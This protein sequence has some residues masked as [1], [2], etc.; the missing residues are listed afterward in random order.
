MEGLILELH[1]EAQSIQK[2]VEA[3]SKQAKAV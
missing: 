3:L 2:L 1:L